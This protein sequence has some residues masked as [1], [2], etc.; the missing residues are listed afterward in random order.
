MCFIHLSHLTIIFF[1][2][3]KSP[4]RRPGLAKGAMTQA[5]QNLVGMT[6][7]IHNLISNLCREKKSRA[8]KVE[9]CAEKKHTKECCCFFFPFVAKEIK[10][11][12]WEPEGV[13]KK[14]IKFWITMCFIQFVP[15]YNTIQ[16][17]I[18]YHSKTPESTETIWLLCF[19][20]SSVT[21]AAFEKKCWAWRT[22]TRSGLF[23]AIRRC[24]PS[25]NSNYIYRFT[26]RFKMVENAKKNSIKIV[27]KYIWAV[28]KKNDLIKTTLVHLHDTATFIYTL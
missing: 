13:H 21:K 28:V 8:S 6:I 15:W 7:R 23:A 1:P 19:I 25:T 22:W 2:Q 17:T 10:E 27:L 11:M 4:W 20:L 26:C 14:Y 5:F 12:V 18:S 24:W 16:I 9:R 3:P